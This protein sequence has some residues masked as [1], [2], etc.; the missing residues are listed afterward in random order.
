MIFSCFYKQKNF[1][2]DIVKKFKLFITEK[3]FV[4]KCLLENYLN[5]IFKDKSNINRETFEGVI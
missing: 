5:S 1:C 2:E 4:K 3:C